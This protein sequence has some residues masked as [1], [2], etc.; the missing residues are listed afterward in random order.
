MTSDL[1]TNDGGGSGRLDGRGCVW[2]TG[3][4][5]NPP[6]KKHR[7]KSQRNVEKS[8]NGQKN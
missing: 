3:Q 2:V 6:Q 4:D 1:P 5:S 8:R 7:F